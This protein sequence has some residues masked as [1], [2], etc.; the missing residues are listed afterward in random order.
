MIS[1]D[2]RWDATLD[3]NAPA[4]LCVTCG[5]VGFWFNPVNNT[6]VCDA[7]FTKPVP[8]SIRVE[9]VSVPTKPWEE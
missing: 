7:C 2:T 1:K 8:G 9:L 6:Y 4:P 5:G 3:P